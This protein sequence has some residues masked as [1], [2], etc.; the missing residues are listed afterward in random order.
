MRKPFW[1]EFSGLQYWK[2]GAVKRDKNSGAFRCVFKTPFE[3]K[4]I[5][6]FTFDVDL[7]M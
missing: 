3:I 5:I 2:I 7:V 4:L 1:V 6:K